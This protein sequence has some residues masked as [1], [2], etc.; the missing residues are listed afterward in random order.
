MFYIVFFFIFFL[1]ILLILFVL[2]ARYD[3]LYEFYCFSVLFYCYCRYDIFFLYFLYY[4]LLL[5]I[6]K[7]MI[8]LMS[9][10]ITNYSHVETNFQIK[11]IT[12]LPIISVQTFIDKSKIKR[13]QCF[14]A[15]FI[16]ILLAN[17]GLI[18]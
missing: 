4:L 14:E 13:F 15:R 9:L 3:I 2:S 12:S 18:I 6:K 8:F 10:L 17:I 11:V 16:H 7:C 1:L 5:F